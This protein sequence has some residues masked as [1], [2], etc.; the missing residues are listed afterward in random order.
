MGFE[1][2]ERKV[3][4]LAGLVAIVGIY[5]MVLMMCVFDRICKF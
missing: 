3:G 2:R 4:Y 5:G 1:V